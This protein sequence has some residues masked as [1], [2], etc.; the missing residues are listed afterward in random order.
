MFWL[1]R[2]LNIMNSAIIFTKLLCWQSCKGDCLNVN[3]LN[4]RCDINISE[5][6]R[7]NNASQKHSYP[8]NVFTFCHITTLGLQEISLHFILFGCLTDNDAFHKLYFRLWM[9]GSILRWYVHLVLTIFLSSVFKSHCNHV[10]YI[11]ILVG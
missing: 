9:D 6:K 11:V 1:L 2:Y 10:Q 3:E 7:R 4:K 5:Y 8:F